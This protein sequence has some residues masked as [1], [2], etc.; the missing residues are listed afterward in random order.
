[1]PP[2]TEDPHFELDIDY[3]L[4]GVHR[5]S[6]LSMHASSSPNHTQTMQWA[7]AKPN[8]EEVDVASRPAAGEWLY[9]DAVAAALV[10]PAEVLM[11]NQHFP[12]THALCPAPCR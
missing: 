2:V 5:S 11:K 10:M 7:Q 8:K 12:E 1:M 3:R 4:V 6:A 9:D